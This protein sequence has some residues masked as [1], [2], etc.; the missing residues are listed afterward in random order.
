MDGQA[1]L[2][3]VDE[4]LRPQQRPTHVDARS[5]VGEGLR[6]LQRYGLTP[7]PYNLTRPYERQVRITRFGNLVFVGDGPAARR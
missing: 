6:L 5:L 2:D 1:V 7:A 3:S 4:A